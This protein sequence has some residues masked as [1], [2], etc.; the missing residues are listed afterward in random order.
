MKHR[1]KNISKDPKA[2]Q[3]AAEVRKIYVHYQFKSQVLSAQ[4]PKGQRRWKVKPKV[5]KLK[6][7][8]SEKKK[9]KEQKS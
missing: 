2:T 1:R 8:N 5:K 9:K 6:A 7:G 3:R 4:F